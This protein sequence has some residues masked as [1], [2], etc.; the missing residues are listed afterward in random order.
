MNQPL[1]INLDDERRQRLIDVLRGHFMDEF[2]EDLSAFRAE[3]LLDFFLS[4]LGPPVYNQGV[5]DACEFV[6][7]KL[8]DIEGEVYEPEIQ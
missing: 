3:G 8:T 1:R 6:Q 4:H 7:K 5:R 2:D